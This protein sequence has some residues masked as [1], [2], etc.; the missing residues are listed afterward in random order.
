MEVLP[1]LNFQVK[2]II[3]DYEVKFIDDSS[4]IFKREIRDGD[5]VIMDQK[6]KELYPLITA[7]IPG[8]NLL[9]D[10]DAHEKQKSYE[11][12]VPN[13]KMLDQCSINIIY[14]KGYY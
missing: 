12:L 13:I 5:V 11:G 2:S 1:V 9:I 14:V 8:N 7:A 3:H 10:I 4:L 6:I